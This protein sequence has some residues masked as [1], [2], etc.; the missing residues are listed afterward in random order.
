N[1]TS[2]MG[3]LS[4][5]GIQVDIM[6]N[7][8]PLRRDLQTA[9]REL[10]SFAR[11]VSGTGTGAGTGS[12][13]SATTTANTFFNRLRSGAQDIFFMTNAASAMYAAFSK[14]FRAADDLAQMGFAAER[15]RIAL[16]NATGSAAEYEKWIRA[17]KTATHGTISEMEAAGLG[18]QSLRLGLAKTS[19]EA[20]E[21]VR[22]AT[23]IGQAS[24]Q[25]SGAADAI[26]EI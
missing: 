26:S 20:Q 25:L 9:E 22:V 1:G 7:L 10:A 23:I 5:A 14:P 2:E 16:T 12:L 24:P 8:A 18:Y 11:G 19:E 17:I 15:A 6:G 13:A 3:L 21:F 4:V